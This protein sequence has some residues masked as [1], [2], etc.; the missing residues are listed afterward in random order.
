M[1]QVMRLFVIFA[2]LLQISIP[3]AQ[4]AAHPPAA[5]TGAV[6]ASAEDPAPPHPLL[7]DIRI[8][9]AVA[10]CTDR[11]ALIASVYGYLS[12]AQR[13]SMLMD[14]FLPADH[15]AYSAPSITY[16]FSPTL[17]TQL[18]EQ[19]GWTLAPGATYRTNAAGYEL[20]L[21]LT[22]T[23]A[24]FR[25]TWAAELEAQLRTN[26]GLRLVR[27]HITPSIWFGT[28]SGLRRRDFELGGFA[29]IVGPDPGG[30][31]LYACD[32]IP[33][34]GN[35][36]S[37]E[38]YMGW[39]NPVA[40]EAA[41]RATNSLSR[42]E[43]VS[44]YAIL[45]DEFAKDMIS[46][47]L[48]SRVSVLSHVPGLTGFAPAAGEVY[49]AWNVYTWTVPATDTLIIGTNSEPDS[50]LTF[51]NSPRD[52]WLPS[53]LI[54]G[55]AYTSVGYDYQAR[56]YT[57]IPTLENGGV[58]TRA[59][60]VAAGTTVVD[61]NGNVGPLA[62]GWRVQDAAGQF[63]FFTGTPISMTRTVITTSY[64]PNLK[65]SDG[66]PLTPA[67]LELWDTIRCALSATYDPALLGVCQRTAQREYLSDPGARYTLVPGYSPS[68]Y[69]FYLLPGAY[70]SERL[71]GDGRKLKDVPAAEWPNL[72]EVTRTPIGLGPYRLTSWQSGDRMTFERNP[73]FPLGLP[74]MPYAEIR[75]LPDTG[76]AVG[77]LLAGRVHVLGDE[78]LP[79][80]PETE[81]VFT[82]AS[83]NQVTVYTLP[84]T[85]WEHIDFNLDLY[86]QTAVRTL[87]PAGGVVTTTVGVQAVF[88]TGALTDTATA[89]NLVV[90]QAPAQP[91]SDNQAVRAFALTAT[92]S[93]GQPVTQFTQ[94]ITLII[95]Y[96]D[97]E[98]SQLGTSEDS[99]NVAY[100]DGVSWVNLLPCAGCQVDKVNNRITVALSH[101]TEFIMTAGFGLY[102]PLIQR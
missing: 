75:F 3:G 57:S 8:R 47:P 14:T 9:R 49:Y 64:L 22:T 69:Q 32:Q 67:D 26:C 24:A 17:G 71:I 93:G 101:L 78:T 100:W 30:N 27:N 21:E 61:A 41:L 91:P 6:M 86:R 36:W 10:Y 16:P 66:R 73:Y 51:P 48:F 80:G 39:C 92:T 87:P 19:A 58:V 97:D 18:L 96:T 90:Q 63:V 62:P 70:P 4:G 99:L 65:W 82:A 31:L 33:T 38:N 56:L 40:T 88:P 53:T 55:R 46:L 89:V 94:P 95:D 20:A 12:P 5:D 83:Q 23:T 77:E 2:L 98:L 59:V 1:A 25:Q 13:Q 35:G 60:T 76:T 29:W 50:L 74:A 44:Q 45:Q 84:S 72:P 85:T 68:D 42:P 102:L 54:Y 43:R 52:T 15:W 79:P 81:P 7:D 11:A 34:A 37:G 28:T